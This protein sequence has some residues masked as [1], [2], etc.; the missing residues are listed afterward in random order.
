MRE[1]QKVAVEAFIAAYPEEGWSKDSL[2]RPYAVE[3]LSTH[4]QEALFEN[5]LEDHAAQRSVK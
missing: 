2:L 5:P 3:A 1:K 4:M